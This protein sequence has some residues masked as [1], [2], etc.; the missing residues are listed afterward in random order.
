MTQSILATED[1]LSL[2]DIYLSKY[3]DM[4]RFLQLNDIKPHSF[5]LNEYDKMTTTKI[6]YDKGRLL[7]L[8]RTYVEDKYFNMLYVLDNITLI[9][10]AKN[11]GIVL[12][13]DRIKLI[14]L[15]I[16]KL[17]IYNDPMYDGYSQQEL[18]Q[19]LIEN[20]KNL[21]PYNIILLLNK[22]SIGADIHFNNDE[23]L[24]LAAAKKFKDFWEDLELDEEDVEKQKEINNDIVKI[25]LSYGADI[26]VDDDIALRSA[27]TA[28]NEDI[29][30][31]LMIYGANV[32]AKNN[33]PIV[34]AAGN[35]L[36]ELI[37][38]L[39]ESG[40]DIHV[41]DDAPFRYAVN[42]GGNLSA[43]RLLLNKGADIHAKDDYALRVASKKFGRISLVDLL[44]KNGADV[45][46][47]NDE[48]LRNASK[49]GDPEIV[50]TLLE[51]GADVKA[52]N[53]EALRNATLKPVTSKYVHD[54]IDVLLEYG[55]DI[56][57]NNDEP[58]RYA[59]E[60]DDQ[61]IKFLLSRG[62]NINVLSPDLIEKYRPK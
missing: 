5:Y 30:L 31:I 8:D 60:H 56:H 17:K 26:H 32:S 23:A 55:A 22:G 2:E 4:F 45:H 36:Q 59:V 10:I 18:N 50:K 21:K 7:P 9:D 25:L 62:A 29:V 33:S 12:E 1:D 16:D 58:L 35:G 37:Y 47:M 42:S 27:I 13:V 57:F 28:E 3:N 51:Y 49:R 61:N 39:L 24:R 19:A 40:A 41:G 15:I 43:I 44:L 54:T 14:R 48:A 38:E 46:A 6:I 11:I 34:L 52:D 53:D 20:V